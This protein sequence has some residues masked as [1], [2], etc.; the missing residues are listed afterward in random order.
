MTFSGTLVNNGSTSGSLVINGGANDGGTVDFTGAA[1]NYTGD[2]DPMAGTFDFTSTMADLQMPVGSTATVNVGSGAH[3]V[4]ADFT[5]GAG[6][7]DA[8]SPDSLLTITT[9]ILFAGGGSGVFTPGGSATSFTASGS[10]IVVD[11]SA[12]PRT[13]TVA[14]GKLTLAGPGAPAVTG[15][16]YFEP[17]SDATSGISTN[18]IYT[19]AVDVGIGSGTDTINGVPFTYGNSGSPTT[20]SIGPAQTYTYTGPTVGT[21]T[22][23]STVTIPNTFGAGTSFGDAA[24]AG[25][26]LGSEVISGGG[27]YTLLNTLNYNTALRHRDHHRFAAQHLVRSSLYERAWDTSE[28][29]DFYVSYLDQNGNVLATSPTFDQNQPEG[30]AKRWPG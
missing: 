5:T 22:T 23:G 27:L 10:N 7:V 26:E 14:G 29:R 15:L 16:N 9:E 19:Q 24:A 20:A 13:L 18:A 28:G 2:T 25:G 11:S 4:V 8:A 21:V 6:T 1:M 30:D 3:V 17:T 12:T